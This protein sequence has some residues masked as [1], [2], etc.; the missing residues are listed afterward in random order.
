[1]RAIELLCRGQPSSDTTSAALPL[2][3]NGSGGS[4][5]YDH[6][7]TYNILSLLLR[8]GACGDP[9]AQALIDAVQQG[10]D[11][12]IISLLLD[13]GADVNYKNARAVEYALYA[14]E[15][16]TLKLICENGR[17]EN[18]SLE[19]LL[20][21]AMDPVLFSIDKLGW[22]LRCCVQFREVLDSTLLLEVASMGRRQEV[23]KMLLE[24][25]AS[26]DHME[27]AALGNTVKDGDID[28]TKILLFKNPARNHLP[29][30]LKM[31]SN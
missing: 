31:A 3:L 12:R 6:A 10:C 17:L 16:T 27:A 22:L 28:T 15:L 20:P 2:V 19:R 23:I 25:G 30:L 24:L 1:L 5:N 21:R 8:H 11:G 18:G 13:N 7:D 14:S 29:G 9:L 4:S 26:V